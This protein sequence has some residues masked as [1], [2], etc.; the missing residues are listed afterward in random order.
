M[1][2]GPNRPKRQRKPWRAHKLVVQE[3]RLTMP[4]PFAAI[5]PANSLDVS[6]LPPEAS[7][8]GTPAFKQVVSAMLSGDLQ[9]YA[10]IKG[11]GLQ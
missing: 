4:P 7:Q 2:E 3:T 6:G 5:I 9:E 8:P 1:H 10:A 11:S